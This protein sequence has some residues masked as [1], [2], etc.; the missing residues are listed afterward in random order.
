LTLGIAYVR[1]AAKPDD[2]AE[3]AGGRS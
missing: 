1:H 2:L 3:A